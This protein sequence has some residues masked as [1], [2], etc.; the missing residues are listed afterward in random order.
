MVSKILICIW[1]NCYANNIDVVFNSTEGLQN[2]IDNL[3]NYWNRLKLIIN[4]EI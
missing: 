1:R 4:V 3:F 2:D